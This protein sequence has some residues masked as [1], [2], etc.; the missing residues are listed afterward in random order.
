MADNPL[1]P[2]RKRRRL[3]ALGSLAVLGEETHL[4]AFAAGEKTKAA[5]S[6]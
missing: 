1:A 2:T 6:L 4:T 5:P 3:L